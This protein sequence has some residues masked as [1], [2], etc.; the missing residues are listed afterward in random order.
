MKKKF[1]DSTRYDCYICRHKWVIRSDKLIRGEQLD[2]WLKESI[3][4]HIQI[5]RERNK[6]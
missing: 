1:Y 2:K 4:E 3:S 6:G 5:H